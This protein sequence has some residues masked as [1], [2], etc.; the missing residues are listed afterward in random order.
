MIGDTLSFQRR[1]RCREQLER[2]A[3][4]QVHPAGDR[5]Q[6]AGPQM[7]QIGAQGFDRVEI[8]FGQPVQACRRCR[9]R[10]QQRD[11]DQIETG[12]AGRDEAARLPKMQPHARQAVGPARKGAKPLL[13]QRH[14]LRVQFHGVHGLRPQR[15]RLQDVGSAARAQN[16]DFGT[17]QQMIGQGRGQKVQIG[18]WLPAAIEAVDGGQAVA[19][20]EQRQLRRR[21]GAG[22]QAQARRVAERHAG[23]LDHRH[24]AQRAGSLGHHPRA[25]DLQGLGQFL[26]GRGLQRGPGRGQGE[27]DNRR[28]GEAGHASAQTAAP[29]RH[30]AGGQARCRDQAQGDFRPQRQQQRDAAQT[31]RR[32]TG[33]VGGIQARDVGG[34][35]GEAQADGRGGAEKRDN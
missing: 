31:A 13:R 14:D 27:N 29:D 3:G 4:R 21:F 2:I 12:G 23:T 20:G 26:V 1:D 28:Q 17:L 6:P 34:K 25:R 8:T 18:Q 16:Q 30:R 5:Q 32:C 19:I 35:A 22:Q 7:V 15:Q 33:D 9:E 10:I 11:L 24:H